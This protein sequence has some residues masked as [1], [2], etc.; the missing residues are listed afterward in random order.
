MAA[1]QIPQYTEAQLAREIER[2]GKK[3]IDIKADPEGFHATLDYYSALTKE[4]TRRRAI[5]GIL[6]ANAA[7]PA[8]SFNVPKG[9]R[10]NAERVA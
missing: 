6:P 1:R 4:E 10:L 7:T 9:S 8:F 3:P 2:V 5:R